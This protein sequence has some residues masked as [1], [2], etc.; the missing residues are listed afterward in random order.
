MSADRKI[1]GPLWAGSGLV[2]VRRQRWPWLTT[3]A[4]CRHDRE[5][6]ATG[7]HRSRQCAHRSPKYVPQFMQSGGQ[8]EQTLYRHRLA[9]DLVQQGLSV[10]GDVRECTQFGSATDKRYSLSRL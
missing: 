7:E 10:A 9:S 8:Q 1:D 6:P 2:V 5:N 3:Q 4:P